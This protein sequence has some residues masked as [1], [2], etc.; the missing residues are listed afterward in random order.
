MRDKVFAAL[1]GTLCGAGG[2]VAGALIRQPEINKLQKQVACLQAD[3]DE[4]KRVAAEQNSEIKRLLLNYRALGVFAFAQ[5]RE[6]KNEIQDELVC[7]YA[8]YDY[9]T[10]LLDAVSTGRKLE[11]EEVRFYKQYGKMLED[12]IVDQ[13]ELEQLRPVIME[14]HAH[15]ITSMKECDLQPIFDKIEQYNEE[16]AE[17]RRGHG[18]FRLKK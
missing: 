16:K 15:E 11:P 4:L 17:D 9:L 1:I 18:F 10:L 14:R 2:F 7:Q 5:K 6:L 3:V 12:N 8:S 13:R